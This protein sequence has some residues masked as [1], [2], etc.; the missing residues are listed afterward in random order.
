MSAL[1]KVET[2]LMERYTL[3]CVRCDYLRQVFGTETEARKS[4]EAMGWEFRL[5]IPKGEETW[6]GKVWLKG[7]LI[8][9][10]YCPHC[11]LLV[12]ETP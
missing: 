4:A 11:K 9:Q 2:P 1:T 6:P 10:A 7:Q 5:T 8:E 12:K 3:T